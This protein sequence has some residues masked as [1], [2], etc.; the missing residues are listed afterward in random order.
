MFCSCDKVVPG[1][2]GPSKFKKKD[3]LVLPIYRQSVWSASPEAVSEVLL[4]DHFP[5]NPK[6]SVHISLMNTMSLGSAL[7][8]C[9]PHC[10]LERKHTKAS[11]DATLIVGLIQSQY[12]GFTNHPPIPRISICQRSFNGPSVRRRYLRDVPPSTRRTV[13]LLCL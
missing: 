1:V 13:R 9:T 6:R 4:R 11:P 5:L 3:F 10:P 2:V 7:Y 12:P 8:I